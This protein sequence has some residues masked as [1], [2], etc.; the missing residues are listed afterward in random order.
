MFEFEI[1]DLG[2]CFGVVEKTISENGDVLWTIIVKLCA[3][4]KAAQEY[5]ESRS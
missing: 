5:I 4:R 1:E 3:T 2:D